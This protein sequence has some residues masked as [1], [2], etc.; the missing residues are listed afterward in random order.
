MSDEDTIGVVRDHRWMPAEEQAARL[1]ADGA[2]IIVSLAGGKN[3]RR[4]TRDELSRLVRA[5][6]VVK[7]VWL[8]LLADLGKRPARNIYKDL[9]RFML[10]ITEECDG[11]I[12]DVDTGLYSSNLQ[13]LRAI[14]AV[15]DDMIVRHAQGKKSAA[16]SE[17]RRGRPLVHFTDA[18]KKDAKA[19]WRNTKEFPKWEDVQREYDATIPGFTIHRAFKAW[20]GR[21]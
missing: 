17:A 4:V 19:I 18:Q 6:T 1:E 21:K 20:K 8:F 10:R 11:V 15:A 5:G 14:V 9:M 3:L 7:V 13:H 12:K 16:N 2:R